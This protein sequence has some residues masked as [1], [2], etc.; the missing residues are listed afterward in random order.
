MLFLATSI[1]GLFERILKPYFLIS[2][3]IIQNFSTKVFT[4]EKQTIILEL[5]AILIVVSR[6]NILILAMECH[7]LYVLPHSLLKVRTSF[8]QNQ[9]INIGVISDIGNVVSKRESR[10]ISNLFVLLYLV[11][12]YILRFMQNSSLK[13]VLYQYWNSPQ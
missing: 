7:W 2:M 5:Q 3:T 9:P 12:R 10:I 8:M 11:T 6:E 4:F 13:L 1:V